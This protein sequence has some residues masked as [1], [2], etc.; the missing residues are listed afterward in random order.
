MGNSVQASHY[1]VKAAHRTTE[2]N[3][4]GFGVARDRLSHRPGHVQHEHHIGIRQAHF[5]VASDLD[6]FGINAENPH[7]RH[8]QRHRRRAGNLSRGLAE[9]SHH[10]SAAIGA[11]PEIGVEHPVCGIQRL[12]VVGGPCAA[13]HGFAAGK[14]AGVAGLLQPRLRQIDAAHVD[15]AADQS[16]KRKDSSR[17]HGQGIPRLI[18]IKP[19]QNEQ[20]ALDPV[21]HNPLC[22]YLPRTPNS[23]RAAPCPSRGSCQDHYAGWG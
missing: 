14:C 13:A 5:G 15:T 6:C 18:V 7:D 1:L 3:Y 20:R 9:R 2:A 10:R 19:H 4:F 22:L 8:R 16:H 21:A 12:V 17:H 23:G 11:W